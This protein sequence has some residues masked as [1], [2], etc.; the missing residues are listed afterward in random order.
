[1]IIIIINRCDRCW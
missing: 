1:M